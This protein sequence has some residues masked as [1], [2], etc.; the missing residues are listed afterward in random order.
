MHGHVNAQETGSIEVAKIAKALLTRKALPTI[1][2]DI[3]YTS[4]SG[5]D[6]EKADETALK[7]QVYLAGKGVLDLATGKLALSISKLKER[8]AEKG[9]TF[10]ESN[11]QVGYDGQKWVYVR[12]VEK[13]KTPEVSSITRVSSDPPLFLS[14]ELYPL[15]IPLFANLLKL[16]VGDQNYS[17][18]EVVSSPEILSKICQF[19]QEGSIVR[20]LFKQDC[21]TEELEFDSSKDYALVKR[22]SHLNTC[23]GSGAKVENILEITS[24]TNVNGLWL[25]QF[26]EMKQVVNNKVKVKRSFNIKC[27]S[28]TQTKVTF[29]IPIPPRS[30]VS[31]E[32][33]G[34]SFLTQ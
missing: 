4:L 27:E 12:Q 2:I 8:E 15:G 9:D 1:I 25:P 26:A 31:D 5:L 16:Q 14:S 13:N 3:E 33:F 17:L 18:A 10:I 7:N 20:L 30:I 34:F 6:Y 22:I 32:R 19:Q 21:V 28:L 24:L 23:P 29:D 11:G